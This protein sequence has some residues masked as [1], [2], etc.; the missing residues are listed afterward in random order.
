MLLITNLTV[1][2][3][4]ARRRI[5]SEGAI[6]LEAERILAVG[7]AAE[8]EPR[9]A[10]AQQIN[11]RGMLALPGFIDAHVHSDQALLRSIADDQPWRPFL[12]QFIWP[13][14]AK[15]TPEDA[16]LSLKLCMLEMIKAGTT[17]FVDSIIPTRYPFDALAQ[18]VVDTGMRAV[19]TK[20][21]M[22][23]ASFS[24]QGSR[25]DTGAIL[26]EEQSFADAEQSIRA[27][28]GGA[29]G[30]IQ[31][32]YGPLT[33]REPASTC[34]PEFYWRVSRQAREYGVGITIH[35]GGERDDAPFFQ[36]VFGLRP[37]EFA[38]KN[39]LVGPNVLLIN[40]NWFDQDEI[41]ILAE[42]DTRLVHSPTA[43]MKMASGI[44]KIPQMRDAGITIA[45]GCD[46]GANNNCHDMI[47]EMKA[48]SLLHKIS[49]MDAS[50]LPAEAVLEM[51]TI[52]G[53]RAIG[54]ED[55]IGSL[56]AGKQADIIL[57]DLRQP[58]SMPVY[59][60][61][62]NL[63]YTAHGGDVD[64]V[65][66]AGKI[67]MVNRHLPHVDEEAI[68]SQA[69]ETGQKLLASAGIKVAPTWPIE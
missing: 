4:D 28:H 13:I 64:T 67:L 27:W 8:L 12:N 10:G 43:N 38:Q 15:R 42:T 32:W 26:N 49:S 50:A 62:A 39:G 5:L 24:K 48:A 60:P 47:R 56:E 34:P 46:S 35:L 6:V 51:A 40:G 9:F 11:G 19:L 59:D 29:N 20:Y 41:R 36:R 25:V 57:V 61:I 37:V 23:Q 65:I 7:K 21:V 66:V 69:Q 2:T 14:M 58:H 53:A 30:R 63:V 33:A 22:P 54:L 68:L 44:A 52:E 55:Q 18:A 31:V 16:L 17:C 1:V 45:L 3:M